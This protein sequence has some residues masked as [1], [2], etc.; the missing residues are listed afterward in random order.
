MRRPRWFRRRPRGAQTDSAGYRP[1]S[2]AKVALPPREAPRVRLGFADGTSVNLDTD[3]QAAE[4]IRDAAARLID[5]P[6]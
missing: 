2:W 4:A 3:S 5:E 6:R 1:G